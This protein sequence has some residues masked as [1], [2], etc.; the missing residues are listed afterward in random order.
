MAVGWVGLAQVEKPVRLGLFELGIER[1]EL[2]VALLQLRVFRPEL[3]DRLLLRVDTLR[4]RLQTS[5]QFSYIHV[6]AR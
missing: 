3:S 4:Q 6:H 5:P 1:L 2:G